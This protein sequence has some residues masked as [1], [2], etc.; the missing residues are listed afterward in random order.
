VDAADKQI[1]QAVRS[2]VKLGAAVQE[3]GGIAADLPAAAAADTGSVADTAADTASGKA[4]DTASGKTFDKKAPDGTA[5]D[6]DSDEDSLVDE[7]DDATESEITVVASVPGGSVST[8]T[9][10][11]EGGA[12]IIGGEAPLADKPARAGTPSWLYALI[13]LLLASIGIT[14]YLYYVRGKAKA[15]KE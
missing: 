1:E 5:G 13:V 6:P 12:T 3:T 4:A 7:E 2:L 9:P 15:K 8:G 10:A 11:Y 14:A